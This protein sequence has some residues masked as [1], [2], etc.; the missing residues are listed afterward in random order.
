[1]V[2]LQGEWIVFKKQTNKQT[3]KQAKQTLSPGRPAKYDKLFKLPT[4]LTSQSL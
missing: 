1:M 2:L 4:L 3:N